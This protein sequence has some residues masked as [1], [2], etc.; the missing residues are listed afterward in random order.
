MVGGGCITHRRD[1]VVGEGGGDGHGRV[2]HA[3]P[4]R[5]E[6]HEPRLARERLASR[7]ATDLRAR[8]PPSSLTSSVCENEGGAREPTA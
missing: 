6:H 1:V 4:A 8:R 2:Q 5:V 7:H 3:V